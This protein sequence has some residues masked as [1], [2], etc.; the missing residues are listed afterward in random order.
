[1]AYF[2]LFLCGARPVNVEKALNLVDWVA[3]TGALSPRLLVAGRK[4]GSAIEMKPEIHG[5]YSEYRKDLKN[6]PL[7]SLDITCGEWTKAGVELFFHFETKTHTNFRQQ[8]NFSETQSGNVPSCRIILSLSLRSDVW[9]HFERMSID[10]KYF[11]HLDHLFVNFD[12][13]YGY[14]NETPRPIA[15][16]FSLISGGKR[17]QV[18][19]IIDF[20]Y[21]NYIEEVYRHNYLS[22]IHLSK[23]SDKHPS[24]L[25]DQGL[26]C[27]ELLDELGELKGVRI[28]LTQFSPLHLDSVRSYLSPLV[29]K[30]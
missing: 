15:G 5:D 24:G 18:P 17:S 26:E 4:I 13:S 14:V 6:I 3:G 30:Q 21:E 27:N 25:L 11:H 22:R 12:C 20:D 10:S 28:S 23:L 16:S 19:R 8:S 9:Q 1:M 2:T 7:A 29:W